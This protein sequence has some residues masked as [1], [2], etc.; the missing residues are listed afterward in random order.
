MLLRHNLDVMHI[1][2]NFF[3]QLIHTVMDVKDETSD[4]VSARKDMKSV[5]RRRELE[6]IDDDK[7]NEV[8][9]KAPY[10]LN[11]EQK[12]VLCDWIRDL[13]FLDGYASNLSRCV[14]Q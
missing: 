1:E 8:M 2:K 9:P 12:K 14:D 7:G 13:R 4:T 5:C 10:A 3:E 6:L 11:K